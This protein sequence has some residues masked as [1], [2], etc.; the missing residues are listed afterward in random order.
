MLATVIPN[1]A[2][3][4]APSLVSTLSAPPMSLSSLRTALH[5]AEQAAP[6]ARERERCR[7]LLAECKQL[8]D[9]L[10]PRLSDVALA[11]SPSS[12]D[13]APPPPSPRD[14][15]AAQA[16]AVLMDV[17][18]ELRHIASLPQLRYL[19]HRNKV[20]RALDAKRADVA[21]VMSAG[22]ASRNLAV[23]PS[24]MPLSAPVVMLAPV[25]RSTAHSVMRSMPPPPAPDATPVPTRGPPQPLSPTSPVLRREHPLRHQV[26]QD[27]SV[28]AASH[29]LLASFDSTTSGENGR[30]PPV[31][32]A[33]KSNR[34]AAAALSWI[35]ALAHNPKFLSTLR[36]DESC[37]VDQLLNIL[38]V[39]NVACPASNSRSRSKSLFKLRV[40]SECP[41]E[42]YPDHLDA[43]DM[44]KRVEQIVQ[45][46][47]TLGTP[48]TGSTIGRPD[49]TPGSPRQQ[50][51]RPMSLIASHGAMSWADFADKATMA[52]NRMSLPPGYF[53]PSLA[54]TGADGE[55]LPSLSRIPT[56]AAIM[57]NNFYSG[58]SASS[59]T[60][61]GGSGPLSSAPGSGDSG[62]LLPG[63]FVTDPPMQRTGSPLAATPVTA[64]PAAATTADAPYTEPKYPSLDRSILVLPAPE[65]RGSSSSVQFGDDDKKPHLP[66]GALPAVGSLTHWDEC[67]VCSLVGEVRSYTKYIQLAVLFH[68]NNDL[69]Q[70]YHLLQHA[71]ELAEADEVPVP[72][73][74]FLIALYLRHGWGVRPE[75]AKSFKFLLLSLEFAI[76]NVLVSNL[77]SATQP[78]PAPL[79][80]T[81][82]GT[83]Q[84]R[85]T[86]TEQYIATFRDSRLPASP[87]KPSPARMGVA[88]ILYEVAV[89]L[90]YSWGTRG[91]SKLAKA[92]VILAANLGDVQ[93][94]VE[95]GS[96]LAR[97]A[98]R[99]APVDAIIGQRRAKAHRARGLAV[100]YLRYAALNGVQDA[101]IGWALSPKYDE[102]H[103]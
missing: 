2:G 100:L 55:R 26:S 37:P 76:K 61:P 51:S 17:A 18:L 49:G 32:A 75:L 68:E 13:N 103:E 35:V 90:R 98:H 54:R 20:R 5:A 60:T 83:E 29:R 38:E 1:P 45:S 66:D 91:N 62:V 30:A 82:F 8:V 84:A 67:P 39:I 47:E 73:P 101:I 7:Q 52:H 31:A 99:V 97:R 86:P 10:A 71:V 96:R 69:A 88:M 9:A 46:P 87:I 3:V 16:S 40:E 79:A 24:L 34:D 42:P 65:R 57:E 50:T 74:Y 56:I 15:V 25:P 48:N 21:A 11:A 95:V 80:T 22:V 64:S 72:T 94:A 85:R 41:A 4:P 78:E 12:T 77:Q 36:A 59:S 81:A 27:S 58:G 93:A 23:S 102:D 43:D 92:L 28:M 44:K 89:S 70:S 63:A 6:K 19:L 53:P 14:A 33:I